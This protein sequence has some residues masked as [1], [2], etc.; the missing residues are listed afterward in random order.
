MDE[1]GT[2]IR[3]LDDLFQGRT[4]ILGVGVVAQV[5]KCGGYG[6]RVGN[7]AEM[8]VYRYMDCLFRRYRNLPVVEY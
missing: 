8:A 5:P 7:T 6:V 2:E 4:G 3:R 1:T